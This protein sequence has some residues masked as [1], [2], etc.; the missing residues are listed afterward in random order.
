MSLRDHNGVERD[1]IALALPDGLD[2]RRIVVRH[3]AVSFFDSEG[4]ESVLVDRP[5]HP[6]AGLSVQIADHVA[7]APESAR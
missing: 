7:A 1:E 5:T 2:V 6:G 3:A 4:R